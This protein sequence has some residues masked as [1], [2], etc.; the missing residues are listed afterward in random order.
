MYGGWNRPKTKINERMELLAHVLIIVFM[1]KFC[2]NEKLCL[3]IIFNDYTVYSIPNFKLDRIGK[4]VDYRRC[5]FKS[6]TI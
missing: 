4:E 2:K 3:L 6:F 1:N 5:W